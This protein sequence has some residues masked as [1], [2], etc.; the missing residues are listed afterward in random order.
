MFTLINNQYQIQG[1][2]VEALTFEYGT[3]TYLYN[4]D[5]ITE[6]ISALKNH[7][8]KYPDTH[9]LYAIKANYNPHIVRH[10]IAR[11]FGI[12]AVS[13]EE[14]KMALMCGCAKENIMYTENNISDREMEEVHELGILLNIGSL[15]RLQ[16][17]AKRY[18]GSDVCVRFN[19]DVGAGSHES[20]ITGGADSKFGISHEQV[21][22]V[23]EIAREYGLNVI[24]IHSHIGSG[25]LS[26]DEPLEA[27][28]AILNIANRFRDLKFI[29]LGGGFGVPYR[30]EEKPLDLEVL[31]NAYQQKFSQFC[32]Q[33]GRDLE[34]RFEPGRY[35]VAES[36]HLLTRVTDKKTSPDGRIF[37]GTDTGMNQLVR[38]AMYGSYHPVTNIS[39]PAGAL[40]SCDICGNV[41][42]CADYFA[43]D[44]H[45]PEA[46]IGDLL[47]IDV[48]GAYGMSMA[49]NYQLRALPA[50]ILVAD[51]VA[52]LIR[53]RQ[54]FEEFITIYN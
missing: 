26:V 49:S 17:F 36:G 44:R 51:G 12:D 22:S 45:I 48:A 1:L 15:T 43:R 34:M 9:F 21:D 54:T 25:W 13:I 27:M 24:G 30:P 14:V 4:L 5:T 52:T 40:Q 16:R 10:I 35:V 3:P 53:P 18:P 46:R 29:D 33:Y 20:N 28:D 47:S 50:E 7:L 11:G 31:G 38:P 8:G 41:C 19:P 39:N 42:E 32:R 37:V 2:S 23:P 6:R